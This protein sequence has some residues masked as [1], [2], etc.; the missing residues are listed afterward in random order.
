MD[1]AFGI[2]ESQDRINT[3][4]VLT[5][6]V[7]PVETDGVDSPIQNTDNPRTTGMSLN[8]LKLMNRAEPVHMLQIHMIVVHDMMSYHGGLY[9]TNAWC[10]EP[11]AFDRR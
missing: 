9:P 7:G 10:F 6:G 3:V 11:S 1:V 2:Q 8:K 5:L 4:K